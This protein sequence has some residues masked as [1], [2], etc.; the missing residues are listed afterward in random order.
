M[1]C[2][3]TKLKLELI[4]E[5]LKSNFSKFN[6][7]LVDN[8]FKKAEKEIQKAEKFRKVYI[9]NHEELLITSGVCAWRGLD[10]KHIYIAFLVN[11]ELEVEDFI[12]SLTKT[13]EAPFFTT[14]LNFSKNKKLFDS[15]V[16]FIK[17]DMNNEIGEE[18]KFDSEKLIKIVKENCEARLADELWDAS[19]LYILILN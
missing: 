19:R 6:I 18:P 2:G 17:M 13:D 16:N 10:F 7:D 5:P 12:A 15:L 4:D 3:G 1:G 8:F 9:D 14:H 11:C